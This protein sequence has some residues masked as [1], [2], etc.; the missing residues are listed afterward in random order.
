M[1]QLLS[2][3]S[4]RQGH[5][6]AVPGVTDIRMTHFPCLFPLF[7]FNNPRTSFLFHSAFRLWNISPARSARG[8]GFSLLQFPQG[9]HADGC[10]AH[11]ILSTKRPARTRTPRYRPEPRGRSDHGSDRHPT[12]VPGNNPPPAPATVKWVPACH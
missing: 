1:K 11:S 8:L 10:R 2:P 12:R 7:P 3:L 5:W 4:S 6:E 9:L